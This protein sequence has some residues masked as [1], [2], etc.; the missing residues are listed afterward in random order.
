[1]E[2]KN[3]EFDLTYDPYLVEMAR[4]P[5]FVE[6]V[7]AFIHREICAHPYGCIMDIHK[8]LIVPDWAVNDYL[9]TKNGTEKTFAQKP[10]L[11]KISSWLIE[12][13]DHANIFES[14]IKA[15]AF[16]KKTSGKIEFDLS[17]NFPVKVLGKAIGTAKAQMQRSIF[18]PVSGQYIA[19]PLH[20]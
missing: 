2:V 8:L 13:F 16:R 15:R 7:A 5:A 3:Y 14:D 10:S 11:A 6:M 9:I 18:H 1:M 19:I 20:C 17:L 4:V 12:A